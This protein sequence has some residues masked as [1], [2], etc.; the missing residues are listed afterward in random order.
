MKILILG[1]GISGLTA[2]WRLG[3]L[4]PQHHITLIEKSSRLGGWI[5][6]GELFEKGPRTFSAA[7]SPSLLRL[8]AEAGLQEEILFSLPSAKTRYLWHRGKLQSAASLFWPHAWRLLFEPLLPHAKGEETIHAYATRRFGTTVAELFFDPLTLGVFA[9]DSR[10]LSMQA[11]FPNLP[12]PL[13][14]AFFKRKEKFPGA[15]FTLK[16]GM[17]SL[18][19]ALTK[20]LQADILLDTEVVSLDR[21]QVVTTR[22]TFGADAIFSALPVHS[23]GALLPDMPKIASASLTVV[24]IGFSHPVMT[25]NGYGYLVPSKEKEELLGMIFD[26]EVF[27]GPGC[28]LTAMVRPSAKCPEKAALEGL[29]R[30]LGIRSSPDRLEVHHA[31]RAIPQL[32]VGQKAM[33]LSWEAS[34]KNF[35]ILGNYMD[36]PGVE[37]CV[38]RSEKMIRNC[39]FCLDS[40]H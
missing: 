10:T 4:L 12:S 28:K 5:E 2:A 16:R 14:R 21:G 40:L 37:Q 25:K 18:V 19:D 3:K 29:S 7:R 30:H 32:D 1:G 11:C 35:F 27:G 13:L 9:G 38:A 26:S 22:G 39:A 33:L 24:N 23:L 15:L 6:T 36:G 8:I 34:L 20:K 31:H 17:Q